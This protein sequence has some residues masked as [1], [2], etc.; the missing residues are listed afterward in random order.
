MVSKLQKIWSGLFIPD[1]G[2]ECWLS[3]IPDPGSRGQKGTR[4]RIPD[5]DPQHCL[6]LYVP[7]PTTTAQNQ[8]RSAHGVTTMKRLL[9]VTPSSVTALSCL[10]CARFLSSCRVKFHVLSIIKI[11]RV[12]TYRLETPSNFRE[13]SLEGRVVQWTK[14][15]GTHQSGNGLTRNLIYGNSLPMLLFQKF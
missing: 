3:P 15:S 7:T 5:P 11:R 9:A 1:P 8:L 6:W 10:H 13:C 2:S 12:G 4:S 14:R